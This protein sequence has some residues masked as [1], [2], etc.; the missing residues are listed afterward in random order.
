M[1][2]STGGF[3]ASETGTGTVTI[4]TGVMHRQMSGQRQDGITAWTLR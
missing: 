1:Y 4:L 3:L 2:L